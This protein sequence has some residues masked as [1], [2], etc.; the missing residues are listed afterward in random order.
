MDKPGSESS[1][2]L[3]D[4][5]AR[6]ITAGNLEA[7]FL[8]SHGMLGAS[9]CYKG[10]ELLR[11]VE[12]LDAAAA[13]GSTAGIPLLHPWAN[14]LA[15]Y[16]YGVAGRLVTLD[17]GSALLHLDE[18]RLP[19]HGVPWSLLSWDLIEEQKDRLVARLDWTRGDLLEIF[20][21][22]HR[23][24]M[25][26]TI[27]PDGMTLETTLAASKDGPVPVSFGFHPY[28]G[29]PGLARNKW[30]L[31]LPAMRKLVL[32]ARNIPTGEEQLF[33]GFNGELE[34]HGFDACFAMIED[35][36]ALTLS[37]AGY[38]ISVEFLRGYRYAQVFAPK[39]KEYVALEPMTAPTNAL[40][41]GRGLEVVEPGADFRAAFGISITE[42]Q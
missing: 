30:R 21:F 38:R 19:M 6:S 27:K 16:S 40:A 17:P 28:F 3:K 32:D 36:P 7:I 34:E 41:S 26:A 37:G 4:P 39:D 42:Y 22:A 31:E 13:K 1:G 9:L 20:P 18:F 35:Q 25:A 8:P 14:R 10:V 11:R 29:L 5:L 33:E 15:G 24:E 12:D 23:L 2:L